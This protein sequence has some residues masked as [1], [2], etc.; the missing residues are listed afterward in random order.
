MSQHKYKT[1]TR[2]FA[3]LCNLYVFICLTAIFMSFAGAAFADGQ[4]CPSLPATDQASLQKLARSRHAD[5]GVLW[6]VSKNG[7]SAYLYGVIHLGRLDWDFP[8]PI[9]SQSLI[10]SK[11]LAVELDTDNPTLAAR[12]AAATQ[13]ATQA[14]IQNVSNPLSISDEEQFAH[15]VD[16]LLEAAC[17]SQEQVAGVSLGSRTEI[18][19]FLSAR[20][21]GIF[22]DFAID[23][24]VIAYM[25]VKGKPLVELE[26]VEEQATA[27]AYMPR[28]L[29]AY[30]EGL[31]ERFESGKV[32]QA[33]IEFASAW[34]AG[35]IKTLQVSIDRMEKDLK[36]QLLDDRN[37]KLARRIDQLYRTRD[38]AFVAIGVL[39]LVG[40]GS[41]V[42]R[43]GAMGY[44][45]RKVVPAK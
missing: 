28:D 35:D 2:R 45:L 32:R 11:L 25:K 8:G 7:H 20:D 42:E 19:D 12:M 43:L 24:A 27:L 4:A 1:E 26:S 38:G 9:V 16:K 17:I 44:T 14:L 5:R 39:H 41:V 18:L 10:Q 29:K 31:L 34:E 15:R 6:E 30:W 36:K 37:E 40:D 3:N 33:Q 22:H 21:Q 13:A 23:Q